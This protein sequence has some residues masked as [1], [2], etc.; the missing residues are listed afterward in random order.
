MNSLKCVATL[1]KELSR[2]PGIGEKTAQRLAFHILKLPKVEAESL[3]R[4]I[5]DV[6]EKVK[7]CSRCFN[8]TEEDPCQI[9]RDSNRNEKQICV[10]EEPHDLLAIEKTGIFKG[11]YH[12][13]QGSLS[14]LDG[15]GPDDIRV[16]ELLDR[17]KGNNVDEVI[18]A[19]NPNNDGEATAHYLTKVTKS[20]GVKVTKIAQ[21]IPMGGDLEYADHVTI[22]KAIEGRREI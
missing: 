11:K 13:L 10:V 22:G 16:R 15:R 18:I 20:L 17:L 2:L 3:A 8:I 9:C 14:P 4:S 21:G 12:V 7:I 6:K 1:V 19:T 5:V